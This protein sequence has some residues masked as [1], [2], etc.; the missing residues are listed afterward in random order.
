MRF[1]RKKEE[2]ISINLTPL[3]DIIFILIIFIVVTAQYRQIS[4][5]K[6]TLPKAASA[7]ALEKPGNLVVTIM[8]NG[9]L[10]LNGVAISDGELEQEF[11]DIKSTEEDQPVVVIQSDDKAYTGRLVGVMD[12]ASKVGLRRISI[13]TKKVSQ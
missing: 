6:V 10:E 8:P 12:M 4:T 9:A 1:R 3:V 13:E 2:D 11:K 7:Q 5:L